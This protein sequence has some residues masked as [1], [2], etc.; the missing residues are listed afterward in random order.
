MVITVTKSYVALIHAR[1]SSKPFKCNLYNSKYKVST[2][3]IIPTL[4]I[5]N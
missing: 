3:I 2:T 1:E 5:R 4:Q